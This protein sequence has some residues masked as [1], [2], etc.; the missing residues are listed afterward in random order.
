MSPTANSSSSVSLST[1]NATLTITVPHHTQLES[2]ALQLTTVVT[3]TTVTWYLS[4]DE[5]GDQPLT[6]SQT[7][8]IVG[9]TAGKGGVARTIFAPLVS[10]GGL[11][12]QALLDAGTANAIAV[13][14][15][16]GR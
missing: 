10:S 11:Y 14:H 9:Q 7:D 12:V 2:I 16:R 15:T 1:S 13:L 8:T 4:A 6:P 3:A 5:D